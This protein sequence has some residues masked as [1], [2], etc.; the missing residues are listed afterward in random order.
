MN[1][2]SKLK[3]DLKEMYDLG[4]TD[5][6]KWHKKLWDCFKFNAQQKRDFLTRIDISN[7]TVQALVLSH[8]EPLCPSWCPESSFQYKKITQSFLQHKH[9]F[10][11][12]KV[13]PIK[14][15]TQIE[16][17]EQ[18]GQ[19]K[20]SKRIPLVKKEDLQSWLERKALLGGFIIDNRKSL[21]IGPVIKNY[22]QKE[23]NFVCHGSVIF[24]GL[25]TV[26][27]NDLFAKTYSQGIGSAKS[28]GFGLMLLVPLH[29]YF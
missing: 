19:K 13:N 3:F 6:Y 4:L 11:D 9:Y 18:G 23:N 5:N 14:T 1:Y 2:L 20:Y 28:F 15:I 27:D 7:N 22:F 21:D 29:N 10:F 16:S 8:R 17:D 24:K 26:N 25:L 12:L